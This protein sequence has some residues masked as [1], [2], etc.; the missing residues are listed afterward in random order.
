MAWIKLEITMSEDLRKRMEAAARRQNKALNEF[1]QEA[2]FT[3]VED[4]EDGVAGN[5]ALTEEGLIQLATEGGVPIGVDD[6]VYESRR[7]TA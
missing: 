7:K 1:A 4:V 6:S 3:Y 5:I 2:L